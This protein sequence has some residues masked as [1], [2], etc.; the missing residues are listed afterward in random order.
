MRYPVY[1]NPHY[2]PGLARAVLDHI[3]AHPEQWSQR[4]WHSPCCTTH[5]IAGTACLLAEDYGR[6][7]ELGW[8]TPTAAA[9]LMGLSYHD[10]LDLFWELDPDEAK[11]L[12]RKIV[13]ER[14]AEGV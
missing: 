4:Y 8:R 3:E 5:C 14:E 6:R 12:L 1:E 11:E 10:S 13:E 7:L 9:A 2:M